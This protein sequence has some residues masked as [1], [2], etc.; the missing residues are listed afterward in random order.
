METTFTVDVKDSDINGLDHVSN[1]AYVYY[2]DKARMDWYKKNNVD[3]A[4]LNKRNKGTSYIKLE[5]VYLNEGRSGDTLTIKTRPGRL[6]NTS[7]TLEQEIYNQ[8][9]ELITKIN[10]VNVMVDTQTRK[11]I[12]VDPEISRFFLEVEYKK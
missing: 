11:S 6:G 3:M 8:H 7:F 12:P 9:N 10:I 4:G 5:V 2:S 1:Y